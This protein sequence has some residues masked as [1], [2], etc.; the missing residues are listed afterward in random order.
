MLFGDVIF[1]FSFIFK[2]LIAVVPFLN[3]CSFKHVEFL[4]MIQK[5][6]YTFKFLATH[7]S[8]KIWF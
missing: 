2:L 1:Q 4:D 5:I 7:I 6:G 8:G 3:M